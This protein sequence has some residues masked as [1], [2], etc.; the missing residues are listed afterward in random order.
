MGADMYIQSLHKKC[1]DEWKPKFD[2]AVF[3]RDT[4]FDLSLND[5]LQQEVD[6]CYDG[7]YSD[8]YFRDS[9]N[10]TNLLWQ[11]GLSWW[12]DMEK[13]VNRKGFMSLRNIRKFNHLIEDHM[14]PEFEVWK[15][16][17]NTEYMTIDDKDN[18]FED[19]YDYFKTK[20]E[21]LLKFLQQAID[22]KEQIDCSF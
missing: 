22:L 14:L 13:L 1:M 17:L 20:R 16:N 21:D 6:K 3:K 8:G 18:R 4:N 15:S 10:S 19:W 12:E 5:E 7:M 2:N 9:Y 11:L